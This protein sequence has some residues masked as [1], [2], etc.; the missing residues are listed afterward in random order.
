MTNK[1]EIHPALE[2]GLIDIL[3]RHGVPDALIPE[4][5]QMLDELTDEV[6]TDLSWWINH[7][8]CPFTGLEDAINT[9]REIRGI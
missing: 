8:N 5:G 7:S 9:Y 6:L 3:L 1:P 2:S 4:H